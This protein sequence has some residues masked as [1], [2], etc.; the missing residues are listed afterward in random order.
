[1]TPEN[2]GGKMTIKNDTASSDAII[3]QGLAVL[4]NDF[5]MV[6]PRL[7]SMKEVIDWYL[8]HN[9]TRFSLDLIGQ[10]AVQDDGTLAHIMDFK[11]GTNYD[12]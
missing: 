9:D 5:Q 8:E 12:Y 3:F 2:I 10:Y 4:D 11:R 6:T 1:M 7:G